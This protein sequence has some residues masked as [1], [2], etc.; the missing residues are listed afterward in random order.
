MAYVAGPFD[1]IHG[2]IQFGGG[3][4]GGESWSCGIRVANTEGAFG[5]PDTDAWDME[6]LLA[7]Y[8]TCIASWF[9]SG[10]SMISSAAKLEH[11]K[12]N[13]IGLNGRYHDQDSH[14][15]VFTPIQGSNAGSAKFPNQVALAITLTTAV[16][17]GPANKGRFYSPLPS[18]PVE[19]SDGMITAA[20]ADL[21]AASATTLIEAI[22]DTPGLDTA[23]DPGVVVM[24][25]KLGAP[26]TRR[27]S[28]V[29]VGRVLDT[30]RRRRRSLSENYSTHVVDQGLL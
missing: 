11:V 25:R 28:G 4:P 6:N 9:I 17:R 2:L 14:E 10:D 5:G 27:V 3:L 1:R 30:Q 23:S 19:Q 29:K 20:N 16:N 12:F 7:H 22:S 26:Y 21:I 13:R 24:S 15:T 18:V 8:V